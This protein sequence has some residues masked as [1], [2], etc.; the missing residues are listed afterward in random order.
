MLL[1]LL[2]A[3]IARPPL[4]YSHTKHP[5]I[6]QLASNVP[7][8]FSNEFSLWTMTLSLTPQAIVN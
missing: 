6:I 3:N 2:P 5:M 1:C 7:F 8:V 4:F